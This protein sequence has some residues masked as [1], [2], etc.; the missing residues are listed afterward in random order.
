MAEK[1]RA[2][3][4]QTC[5][6]LQ[7]RGIPE[8]LRVREL[9]REGFAGQVLSA[10]LSSF[11]SGALNRGRQTS[12]MAKDENGANTLTISSGHA[13]DIFRYVVGD[14]EELTA[15]LS[16]KLRTWETPADCADNFRSPD[17]AP[18]ADAKMVPRNERIE[19]TSPDSVMMLG[20]LV[21]G[22]AASV[23][24][25]SVP[26]HGKG[27]RMEIYGT[28]GTIVCGSDMPGVQL[29]PGVWLK[30]AKGS[31]AG[32][33]PG[34]GHGN[35][36]DL[37]VP[38]HLRVVNA[39]VPSHLAPS[40]SV[41]L[42]VGQLYQGFSDAVLSPSKPLPDW[43]PSFDTAVKMHKFLDLMRES[44]KDRKWVKVPKEVQY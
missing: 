42:A 3:N 24:I 19:A 25:S 8:L 30:G 7:A 36:Q 10:H 21:S 29:G 32:A 22:A 4:L 12:W 41:A 31:E 23:H 14:F 33:A 16:T 28:E 37:N 17:P 34:S 39:D 15:D 35:L 43:Y 13:I 18:A 40:N 26:F 6:G 9:L 38:P 20:T 2:K 5:C 11:G 1:A 44:S 27:W